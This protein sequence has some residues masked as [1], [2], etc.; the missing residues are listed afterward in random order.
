MARYL[1]ARQGSNYQRHRNSPLNKDWIQIM[2]MV[3]KRA[4]L[5]DYRASNDPAKN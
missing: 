2:T 5:M 1:E 3:V 4:E